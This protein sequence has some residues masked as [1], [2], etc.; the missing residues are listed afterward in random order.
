MKCNHSLT[1]SLFFFKSNFRFL[2]YKKKASVISKRRTDIKTYKEK[3]SSVTY[4]NLTEIN[5]DL[6]SCDTHCLHISYTYICWNFPVDAA[7]RTVQKVKDTI[8][9]TDLLK[10]ANNLGEGN[11]DY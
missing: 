9:A 10:K 3:G 1:V 5:L 11:Q 6:F 4:C 7:N 8:N 2:S